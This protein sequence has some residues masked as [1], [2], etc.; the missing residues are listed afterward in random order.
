MENGILVEKKYTTNLE[1]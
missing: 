1:N